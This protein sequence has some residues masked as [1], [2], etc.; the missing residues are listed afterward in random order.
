MIN[1]QNKGD[2]MINKY[3]FISLF[4]I[5]LICAGCT[6]EGEKLATSSNEKKDEKAV[7][8]QEDMNKGDLS[9]INELSTSVTVESLMKFQAGE[10]TN[11]ITY[12]EDT[13][14]VLWGLE[15]LD[16][17]YI[18]NMKEVLEP[19]AEETDNPEKLMKAL[20]YYTGSPSYDEIVRD[21][22]S[23]TPG[24]NE[25]LLP[26]PEQVSKSEGAKKENYSFILLDASS[27]ML[28]DSEGKLRM[29]I[30]KEAVESFAKAIGDT[31]QVSLVAFGHRGDESDSGKEESCSKIEEVYKMGVFDAERFN[32]SLSTVEAK[33]WTPLATAIEKTREF[34]KDLNGQITIYIVSDG[35]ETCDGNPTKAAEQFV[36]EKGAH[37]VSVNIIGFQVDNGAENQLKAV[38]NAG[39]GEYFAAN[40]EEELL[41]TIEY[42]WLPSML[43]LTWAPVNYVPDGWEIFRETERITDL[44]NGWTA[45]M[46]REKQRFQEGLKIWEEQ[47]ILTEETLTKIEELVAVREEELTRL[48][49]ELQERNKKEIDSKVNEIKEKV[50]KWV[51]EMKKL[52]EQTQ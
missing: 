2:D 33:G 22:D 10:L 15:E 8:K 28:L 32:Q 50:D 23:F 11:N 9:D 45:S 12:E 27:S 26:R 30:A 3:W 39:K 20:V 6:N 34:S 14:Q 29:D 31:S 5:L 43:E 7:A 36:K 21:L 1:R 35:V 52:K 44:T 42:E 16:P 19:L 51:E 46:T 24:F 38:A 4:L 41:S 25:P 17:Q 48:K 13:E 47:G 40:G 37:N 49:D 18:N